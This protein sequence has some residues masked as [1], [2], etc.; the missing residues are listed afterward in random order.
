M[1]SVFFAE[2][3]SL[4]ESGARDFCAFFSLSSVFPVFGKKFPPIGLTIASA[5]FDSVLVARRF[6]SEASMPA[7]TRVGICTFAGQLGFMVL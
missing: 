5:A 2:K 4:V 7:I 3:S 6:H 1:G